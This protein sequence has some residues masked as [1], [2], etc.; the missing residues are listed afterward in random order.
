L[1]T[2]ALVTGCAGFIGS[3]LTESLLADGHAVLG[4]DALTDNYAAADK[5]AN[6]AHAAGYDRFRLV[7]ADLASTDTRAL[8]EDGDVVYHL[9]GEPGVRSSW[10]ERFERFLHHNV[11]A[12]QRLL[13][14][15]RA[16]PERRVVY[17]SSSSIYGDSERLPTPED[18]PPRPMSPYGVTKLAGEQ[19]C[20]VYHANHGVDCVALRFFTVYGPRQRPDMAFRRFCEAAVAGAPIRL[21]GDGRQSRDFTFVGDVVDALVSAGRA[22]GVG[23]R[24]YNVGGGA[25]VSLNEALSTIARLAGRPL[26][27]RRSEHEA[28][29]VSHTAAD[30]GRARRDLGFDPRMSLADGLA[31]EFEWV[32]SGVRR[33]GYTGVSRTAVS[34]RG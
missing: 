15:A 21:F 34:A 7:T 25:P 22:D 31:A 27:V 8:V 2:S 9:A 20:R 3:H 23:G 17:A 29:D 6:L 19:L 32:R 24:A 33:A 16:V 14:A 11:E 5:R 1:S 4:V 28:G 26:D 18:T 30:L 12:T 10:G 13:E